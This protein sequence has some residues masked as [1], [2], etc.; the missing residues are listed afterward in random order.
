MPKEYPTYTDMSRTGMIRKAT[1]GKAPADPIG[2]TQAIAPKEKLF[3]GLS[4]AQV[5]ASAGAAATSMLLAS[6]IGI[7]GSVIGAAVSSVVTLLATQVYRKVLSDGARK[8]QEGARES[9]RSSVGTRA[10]IDG[11][12]ASPACPTGASH[13]RLAPSELRER[14]ARQ[15]KAQQRK[16]AVASVAVAIAAVALAAGGVML[17]T[18]GEGLGEKPAPIFNGAPA[19]EINAAAKSTAAK[20]SS[21]H[22]EESGASGEK[23]PGRKGAPVGTSAPQSANR[24]DHDAEAPA[25]DAGANG[26]GTDADGSQAG[27][28]RDPSTNSAGTDKAPGPADDNGSQGS[29]PSEDT[30][31]Q[32]ESNQESPGDDQAAALAAEGAE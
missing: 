31:Q 6:K 21:A 10:E 20:K 2:N 29:S 3:D 15:R 5:L 8:L 11:K 17:A 9:A 28:G 30:E 26:A 32:P 19:E 4:V 22:R 23:E 27:S 1:R 12:V 25:T 18:A 14:A 7:A 24:A 16:V 13:A